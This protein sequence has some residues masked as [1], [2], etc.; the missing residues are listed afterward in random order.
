MSLLFARW[1]CLELVCRIIA[2]HPR[3]YPG[4]PRLK[5]PGP[6]AAPDSLRASVTTF[7]QCLRR[8]APR[9][10]R[11]LSVPPTTMVGQAPLPI[12]RRNSG[13]RSR[14]ECRTRV[15]TVLLPVGQPTAWRIERARP[16]AGTPTKQAPQRLQGARSAASRGTADG[17]GLSSGD[18]VCVA[19]YSQINP[20]FEHSQTR[21]SSHV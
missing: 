16:Y 3:Y 8:H 18:S 4:L 20:E 7:P 13:N 17:R 6:L 19:S 10:L 15:L 5:A 11:P 12:Q 21:E 2:L 9:P 1:H 14:V